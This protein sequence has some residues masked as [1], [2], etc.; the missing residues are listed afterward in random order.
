MSY[1]YAEEKQS[2]GKVVIHKFTFRID[3]T[4]WIAEKPERR[5]VTKWDEPHCAKAYRMNRWEKVDNLHWKC[6]VEL[7]HVITTLET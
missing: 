6:P 7:N 3:R 4:T 5:R 2:N 1:H